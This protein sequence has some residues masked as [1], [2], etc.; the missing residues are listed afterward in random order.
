MTAGKCGCSINGQCY[1]HGAPNPNNM[2]QK[3]NIYSNAN[4]WTNLADGAICD[5]GN[6]CTRKDKC[7]TGA[8]GG[9]PFTCPTDPTCI[10]SNVCNGDSCDLV[11]RPATYL[12]YKNKDACDWPDQYCTGSTATCPQN[13]LKGVDIAKGTVSILRYSIPTATKLVY[14]AAESGTFYLMMTQNKGVRAKLSGFTVP[15]GGVSFSWELVKATD[16]QPS[17]TGVLKANSENNGTTEIA[18]DNL[19]LD[20]GGVY[21]ILVTAQNVRSDTQ[22]VES[23][24]ILVDTTPPTFSTTI[25]DGN[26]KVDIQYQAAT[27][28][29]SAYWNP[30]G[31]ADPESGRDMTSFQIGAGLKA[32]ETTVVGFTASKANEG[33][34]N[35]L[36]LQHN[37][38][39]YITVSIANRAGLRGQA[40][41]NGVLV[42]TSLPIAG[43]V[44]VLDDKKRGKLEYLAACG[45]QIE[46]TIVNFKDDES[47]LDSFQWLLCKHP[48]TNPLQL[49]C[50]QQGYVE[51]ACFPDN[52]CNLNVTHPE[53]RMIENG[54][55]I[56]EY[57]YQLY[58]RARN[59]AGSLIEELSNRFIVDRKPPI[60]GV[61][62]DGL[63][64]DIDDQ[65]DDQTLSANWHGFRDEISSIDSCELAAF[66]EY[67]TTDEKKVVDYV[68][69]QASGQWTSDKLNLIN[70]KT[71]YINVKC[72][73][74][75][76]LSNEV[77]TDGVVIEAVTLG[78]LVD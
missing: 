53:D 60:A 69:V 1:V 65:S 66:E 18:V 30:N 59:R 76:G 9:D 33:V 72:Q 11:Y 15:C 41:S 55:F 23:Q 38:R 61:V 19:N 17:V 56:N 47:G 28:I 7:T 22:Q 2:C 71:Y 6:A 26:A 62:N 34:L 40:A 4:G 43:T 75:A 12:C 70:G 54:C 50:S 48:L 45:R 36:K 68:K 39:Y 32:Y 13:N 64:V 52:N 37:T 21:K 49:S 46:A 20:N 42:D 67:G 16:T 74:K 14:K 35:N 51:F 44:T 5:D 57:S 31:F 78:R 29:L 3:C 24:L 77:T 58:I 73:N 25:N 8:C 10:E 63:T 27:T